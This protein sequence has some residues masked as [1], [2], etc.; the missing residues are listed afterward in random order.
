VNAYF[1][2]ASVRAVDYGERPLCPFHLDEWEQTK[3]K[4][5]KPLMVLLLRSTIGYVSEYD[6]YI[7][8]GLDF[9]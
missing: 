4:L 5:A 6:D 9:F 8:S 3:T 1:L 7:N 2:A